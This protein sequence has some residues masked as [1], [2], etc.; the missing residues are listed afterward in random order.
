M[1]RAFSVLVVVAVCAS[2]AGPDP[3]P[4]FP[5]GPKP[6]GPYSPGLLAGGM[7]YVSGQG[8]RDAANKLPPTVDAQIRQCL[9][10]VKGVL[11]GGKLTLENVVS[12]NVYLTD[13]KNYDTLNKIWAEYFPKNPPTRTVI[14]VTQMPAGTPVEVAVTAV[15]DLRRKKIVTLPNAK[16]TEPISAAI[17]IGDRVF[18]SGGLGRDLTGSVPKAT[19]AQVKLV[20]DAAEAALKSQ[21]LEMRNMVYTNI[22]V[23]PAM[24]LNELAQVLDDAI[25]DE[26]ARTIIQTNALPFGA[27]I[28]IT[29]I[30]SK[31]HK[32]MGGHCATVAETLYCSGRVGTTRHVLE[33]LKEDLQVGGVGMDH[34]VAANV[35]LD[36]IGDFNGMNAAYGTFFGKFPPTRTTVQP[37]KQVAELSLPP[38][39]GARQVPDDSPRAQISI[40]AVR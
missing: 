24:P 23:D 40:I 32:R 8:A 15:T 1:T 3:K 11:A 25:P 12:A 38:T 22:Y 39:T 28:Q 30:A 6:I 4:V 9:D 13:I 5:P 29:G 20:V 2:S 18:L 26:T 7:M 36:D 35:Y 37:W 10:N 21:G 34:A 16:V 14:G 27:H 17:N 31:D 33:T 19:S